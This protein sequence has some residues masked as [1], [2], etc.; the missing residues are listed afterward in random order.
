MPLELPISDRH[1]N[2]SYVTDTDHSGEVIAMYQV[3]SLLQPFE[4][5][6]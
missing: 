5:E 4:K 1:S 3:V 2:G 6:E